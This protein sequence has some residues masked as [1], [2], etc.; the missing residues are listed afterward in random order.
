MT[1]L[2]KPK[3]P[4]KKQKKGALVNFYNALAKYPRLQGKAPAAAFYAEE[5]A[6]KATEAEEKSGQEDDEE[7]VVEEEVIDAEE[8][9]LPPNKSARGKRGNNHRSNAPSQRLEDSHKWL[10]SNRFR[11]SALWFGSTT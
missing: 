11:S 5:L 10:S 2:I 9:L 7:Y 4:L 3:V 8:L 6:E 1:V